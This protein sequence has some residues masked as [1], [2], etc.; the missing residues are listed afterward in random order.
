MFPS[1]MEP[2]NNREDWRSSIKDILFSKPTSISA[3]F[4][5][6][7][8]FGIDALL[9]YMAIKAS[10]S[11]VLIFLVFSACQAIGAAVHG[12][13]IYVFSR[14]AL[15]LFS[16]VVTALATFA[17][18]EM[19]DVI[20][21]SSHMDIFGLTTLAKPLAILLILGAKCLFT[22]TSVIGK[23]NIAETIKLETMRELTT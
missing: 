11:P 8:D 20:P 22:G 12:M 13:L 23:T 16:M 10:A 19:N 9:I 6:I 21:K 17:A 18:L 15:R 7:V 4:D 3:M 1:R 14:K 5:M 2:A